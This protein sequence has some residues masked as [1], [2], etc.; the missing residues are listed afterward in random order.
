MDFVGEDE[1]SFTVGDGRGGKGTATM[2]LRVIPSG[3]RWAATWFSDLKELHAD[4]KPIGDGKGATTVRVVDWNGDGK[5]DL[6][7][8]ESGTVRWHPNR[9]SEK[10]PVFGPGEE[11]LS[12]GKPIAFG[13]DRLSLAL[14][15]LDRDGQT[16]L[17]V[18]PS[19]D[20]KPRWMRREDSGLAA[21][22]LLKSQTGEDLV[23]EDIRC[24]LVGLERRWSGGFHRRHARG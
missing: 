7:V 14:A 8:G 19:S 6:V 9:G 1:F 13:N 4:G 24:D 10:E 21:P 16:D 5:L 18:V 17:V 22:I 20:R 3:A 12:G 2:R 15:D 11:M 23:L